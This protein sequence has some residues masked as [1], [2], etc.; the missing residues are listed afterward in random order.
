MTPMPLRPVTCPHC[1][2]E[3][4]VN[5]DAKCPA[6]RGNVDDRHPESED[7][8][9]AEFVDGEELPPVCVVCAKAAQSYVT[10]GEKNE[11][12]KN[13]AAGILSRIAAALGGLVSF[14]IGPDPYVKEYKI[15]VNLPV[16]AEHK[17][18]RTLQAI[19]VDYRRYRI[20][21]AA[22]REFIRRWKESVR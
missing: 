8:V 9:P 10:V 18:A 13:D 14:R 22:H 15:S 12:E 6:C 3:V 7:L 16:C 5:A 21:V 19:D 20:T 1:F 11:V 4:Y 17:Q 2:R